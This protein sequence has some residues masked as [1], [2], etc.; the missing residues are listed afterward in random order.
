MNIL[1][2]RPS[3]LTSVLFWPALPALRFEAPWSGEKLRPAAASE[4]L[5][6]N[7]LRIAS[8]GS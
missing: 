6:T 3:V 1:L 7:S 5:A 4:E 2:R 8:F